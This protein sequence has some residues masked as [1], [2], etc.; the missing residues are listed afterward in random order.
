[1]TKSNDSD[2]ELVEKVKNGDTSAFRILVDRYKKVSYSLACSI[3]QDD[4]AEDALQESFIKVFYHI[5]KFRGDS[6]FS[7]WLYRIVVNTC[8]SMAKKQKKKESFIGRACEKDSIA[9]Q[10][11]TGID[12]M[13]ASEQSEMI[14]SVLDSMKSDEALLLRLFY[15]SEMD[16]KEIMKITGY[17]ESKVKVTL[18]RARKSLLLKIKSIYTNDLMSVS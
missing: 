5:K 1:L 2:L 8:F 7:S 13:M 9:D 18:F 3:L 6:S 12:H 15:L 17:K 4:D 14:N 16:L 10:S 11:K